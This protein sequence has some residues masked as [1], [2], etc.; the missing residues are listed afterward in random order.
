MGRY[1]TSGTERDVLGD[2]TS[3]VCYKGVDTHT[4][5]AVA[6]KIYKEDASRKEL[7]REVTLKKFKRQ[8]VV[9]EELQQPFHPQTIGSSLGG[10]WVDETSPSELFVQL[11]DYSTGSDGRPGRDVYDGQLYIVMELAEQSLKEH[12]ELQRGQEQL[13][14]DVVRDI[15]RDIVRIVAGLHAK[16][17]VHLDLKPENVVFC[18]S[19]LKLID[20]DGCTRIGEQLSVHDASI[21]FSPVYCAPEW[22]RFVTDPDQKPLR[23]EPSLDVWSIGMTLCDLI[24][25]EPCL[26]SAYVSKSSTHGFYTWVGA[27]KQ[28]PLPMSVRSFDPEF[29]D[30]LS[31]CML[32]GNQAHRRSLAQCLSHPFFRASSHQRAVEHDT[33]IHERISFQEQRL[34]LEERDLSRQET[35][36][37]SEHDV[38]TSASSHSN[39]GGSE[40]FTLALCK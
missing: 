14:V 6:I 3:S 11:L 38:S 29:A 12:L 10:P 34:Q 33:G 39:A 17:F 32:L 2:G 5:T 36:V 37:C 40:A 28:A 23:V 13:S 27:M 21:S 26:K 20:V 22:A 31:S 25:A 30:L 16:G 35:E 15:S 18:E 8:I 4:G 1:R 9:M 19:R 7:T 24:L